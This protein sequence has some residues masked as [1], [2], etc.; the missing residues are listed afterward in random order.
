VLPVP[1]VGQGDRDQARQT[2]DV[3]G[4]GRSTIAAAA[5]CT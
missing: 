1:S 5:G 4:A 3:P 2:R